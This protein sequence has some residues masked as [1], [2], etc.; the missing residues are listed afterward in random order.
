MKKSVTI[1]R[2]LKE[3]NR[4][5]GQLA[6]TRNILSLKNS[7]A[8]GDVIKVDLE[9]LFKEEEKL[10]GRLV[11]IKTKIAAANKEI[12]GKIVE[13]AEI[14]SRIAWVSGIDTY[15]GARSDRCSNSQEYVATFDELEQA[16]LLKKLQR[17]AN[18]LQ[19]QIDEYNGTRH[20]EIEIEEEYK[21]EP[22]SDLLI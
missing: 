15:E 5:A 20:I 18:R 16:D 17:Q 6:K 13:L 8:R 9:H 4:I 3:K 10:L 2:A 11:K 21:N 12:V 1:A 14:K 7:H 19:D 22:K